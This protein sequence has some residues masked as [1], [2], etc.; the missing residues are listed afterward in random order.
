VTLGDEWAGSTGQPVNMAVF[1]A[2]EELRASVPF[3]EEVE[4]YL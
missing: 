3:D 1:A 2:E 4:T